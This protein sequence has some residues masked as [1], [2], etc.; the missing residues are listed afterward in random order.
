MD[1]HAQA[2]HDRLKAVAE[3]LTRW[4]N[5]EGKN[6]FTETEYVVAYGDGWLAAYEEAAA[7]LRKVLDAQPDT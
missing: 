2:D 5:V 3:L 6:D 4:E 1:R 7:E